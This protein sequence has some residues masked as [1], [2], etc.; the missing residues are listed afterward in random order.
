MPFNHL[1]DAPSRHPGGVLFTVDQHAVQRT[2]FVTDAAISLLDPAVGDDR[3]IV[4]AVMANLAT[5]VTLAIEKAVTT[6]MP[7]LIVL[8]EQAIAEV[9]G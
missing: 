2:V 8:D 7:E 4:H 5:L 6:S 1:V 9:A 3:A